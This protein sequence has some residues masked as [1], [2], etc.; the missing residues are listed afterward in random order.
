MMANPDSPADLSS[1]SPGRPSLVRATAR[2]EEALNALSRTLQTRDR[3]RAA[4]YDLSVSQSHA[5]IA[6]GKGGPKTVT[7]LASYLH[8]EKSTA[9]RLAKGL[10]GRG[11]VRKR[12][13]TSDDRVVILQATEQGLRLSRRILNDLSEE[14]TD[15]LAG[16]DPTMREILPNALE[17][18]Q[19]SL[20]PRT[21]PE[22]PSP[23]A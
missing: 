21:L 22:E 12:S 8:L 23:E 2:L 5:L 4:R 14:Y 7:G 19:E 13:P 10:L 17:C 16:L 15:L 6:L 3:D 11:L 1:V 18:L 9:S 20:A